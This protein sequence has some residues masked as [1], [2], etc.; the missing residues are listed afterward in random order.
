MIKKRLLFAILI[1]VCGLTIFFLSSVKW[2]EAEKVKVVTDQTLLIERYKMNFDDVKKPGDKKFIV[3]W[4]R[5]FNM[6][7]WGINQETYGEDYLKSIN[8]S[9]TQC[10]FTHKKDYFNKT[11]DYDAVIFHGWEYFPG[12]LIDVPSIRSP[13][14]L[15][16]MANHE[17][18][19]FSIGKRS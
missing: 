6:P 16:I 14:Q 11:T 15:Y 3:F 12:Q 18:V 2:E 17:L 7:T 4:T 1:I 19:S 10:V 9:F 8:C 13:N 5:F